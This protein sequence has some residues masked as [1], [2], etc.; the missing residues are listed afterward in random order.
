MKKQPTNRFIKTL[1]LCVCSLGLFGCFTDGTSSWDGDSSWDGTAND[2][3]F[4]MQS[5]PSNHYENSEGYNSS[6]D[7]YLSIPDTE[8][9]PGVVV[10]RSY[11]LDGFTNT[12]PTAKEEDKNWVNEQ[13]RNGYT[14]QVSKDTK[15]APVASKL[16]QM[17]KNERSVEVRTQ[18][19]SYI[20]LHGSYP[21]RE[22]A[23]QQLNSLPPSVKEN[24]KIKNW[25]TIKTEVDN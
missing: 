9:A 10:P 25:Q 6:Y 15:P 23:E 7:S 22:A 21:S 5:G 24:A 1:T 14:I 16:Q 11:H 18:S 17:P 2:G 12:P 19:G 13:N 3:Y 20:G 8:T 4:I